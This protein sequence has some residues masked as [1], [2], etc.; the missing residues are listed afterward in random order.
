MHCASVVDNIPNCA[1]IAFSGGYDTQGFIQMVND[2][3][4]A[5]VGAGNN[6]NINWYK[7]LAFTES[8][9]FTGTP[10]APTPSTSDNSTKIATTAFVKSL[11]TINKAQN[12][13]WRDNTTGFIIQWGKG[14]SGRINYSI[15]FPTYGVPVFVHTSNTNND[16]KGFFANLNFDN[17]GFTADIENSGS[18]TWVAI[19]Y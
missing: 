2:T 17:N 8:P 15:S 7:E 9:A 18:L 14:T 19:G 1:G 3:T 5:W 11:F 12:G 4:R 13:W 16:Y 10:T 6:N